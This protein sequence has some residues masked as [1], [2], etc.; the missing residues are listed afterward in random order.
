MVENWERDL[1]KGRRGEQITLETLSSIDF[2]SKCAFEYV[3]DKPA[4]Y[5][6]GDIRAIRDDGS[7]FMLE[8]KNDERIAETHNVLCEELVVYHNTGDIKDG[9]MYNYYEYYC[10]VS[11]PERKIYILD[12]K[13]MKKIYKQGQ[14]RTFPHKDQTTYGYLLPLKLIERN[15]GLITILDY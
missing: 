3:G 6:Y 12:F 1:E 5:K 4:Y 10:I 11:E 7:I 2:N 8:V 9:Y 13:V 15:D 14:F